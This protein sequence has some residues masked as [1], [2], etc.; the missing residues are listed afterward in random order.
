M[1]IENL[2]SYL[3]NKEPFTEKSISEIMHVLEKYPYF[4][5]AHML[6]LKGTQ[7]VQPDNYN[8]QLK[9]SG[10][11][12]S[13]KR[14]LFEFI[15]SAIPTISETKIE[16]K[17]S[18]KENTD[19]TIEK[20]PIREER[21]TRIKEKTEGQ[22]SSI[23][24][25]IPTKVE[26]EVKTETEKT[27][28]INKTETEVPVKKETVRKKVDLPEDEIEKIADE[29]SKQKHH[30]IIKDFFHPTDKTAI[31]KKTA[32]LK[33]EDAPKIIT[34]EERK[35]ETPKTIFKEEKKEDAPKVIIKENK[36]ETP[37]V[38]I[39]K[40]EK[41]SPIVKKEESPVKNDVPKEKEIIKEIQ[42]KEPVIKEI[43]LKKEAPIKEPI[44]E[45]KEEV[46]AKKIIKETTV[47]EKD[48]SIKTEIT[49][50]KEEVEKITA[51]DLINKKK[52]TTL[53]PKKEVSESD[54]MNN[55]FSKIRQIKK[56]MNID[57]GTTPKTIDINKED[58]GP[59]LKKSTT[60]KS[61]SGR[62]IKESF[63]GFDE[64]PST[65]EKKE[66]VKKTDIEEETEQIKESEL[67]AKDL[68]KKH[69]L[70]KEKSSF[71]ESDLSSNQN[72]TESSVSPISKLVDVV[73]EET[74]KTEPEKKQI[75]KEEKKEPSVI[76]QKTSVKDD[77]K[78][79]DEKVAKG[80]ISAAEALL[81]KIAAKK[82][83]IQQEREE[84]ERKREEEKQKELEAVDQ[85]IKDEGKQ[86]EEKVP[87]SETIKENE[88]KEEQEEKK[89]ETASIK[90]EVP[91]K[92]SRNL[93]DSF[94]E[95]VD[96]LER[97]G[98]KE[99]KLT[100]DISIEST[101]ESEDIMTETYADLL[102]QQKNYTK[103]IDVYNKL[104]LK[105][106][107]KKTYFAIQIKKVESL[108]K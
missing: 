30:K 29:N 28:I 26:S 91:V 92:K 53:Q 84:E 71:F 48:Q 2:A 7:R 83:R 50:I 24:K 55:I 89:E 31:E 51:Q 13:D 47:T 46:T 25:T 21:P 107:E 93:I 108:I 76:E 9:I 64:T 70:K 17:T 56:E 45:E 87:E 40:E 102:I 77:E 32:D 19:K 52:E 4:Q 94:I 59:K 79:I 66:E 96:S 103:A 42:K 1:N 104:I 14:K 15:N 99:S 44:K 78:E 65:I 35:E 68:F 63:I 23:S 38:V 98:S 39:R 27:P 60:I 82:R 54:A 41:E 73:N 33:K 80:E 58:D 43:P 69:K 95:K 90:E 88:T 67:T 34:K 18:E 37:K 12:V 10:S 85:L 81:Q 86:E 72:T 75:I 57:S 74:V 6:L 11:F 100:G 105:F 22:I 97:I 20:R 101:V 3:K 36:E 62:V 106:P 61:P 49:P 5:I 16:T 8:K